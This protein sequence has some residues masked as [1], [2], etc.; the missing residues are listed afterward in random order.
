[1][2][3]YIKFGIFLWILITIFIIYC[4]WLYKKEEKNIRKSKKIRDIEELNN[5]YGFKNYK[6]KYF[7]NYIVKKDKVF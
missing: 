4:V 1:M 6:K 7:I 2:E 3:I 5:K